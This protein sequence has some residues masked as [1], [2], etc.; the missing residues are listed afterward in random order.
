MCGRVLR[1]EAVGEDEEEGGEAIGFGLRD[2]LEDVLVGMVL[3][4]RLDVADL[5]TLDQELADQALAA[6]R[7]DQQGVVVLDAEGPVKVVVVVQ[8]RLRC[9]GAD[10]AVRVADE[11]P[12]E[13]VERQGVGSVHDSQRAAAHRQA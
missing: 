5:V 2:E 10:D 7:L 6:K 1:V 9:T 8:H 4:H 11:P 12:P 13:A 3:G